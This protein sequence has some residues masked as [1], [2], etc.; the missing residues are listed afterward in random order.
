[1][2]D[3]Q[4]RQAELD[5]EAMR[6]ELELA[7]AY[8]ELTKAM[9]NR[10]SR[11][12]G[13]VAGSSQR[14]DRGQAS[15]I[16]LQP[17]PLT[18]S[19]VP[20]TRDVLLQ[21]ELLTCVAENN[22]T[23]HVHGNTQTFVVHTP[24]TSHAQQHTHDAPPP[25]GTREG[26]SAHRGVNGG[27]ESEQVQPK[28]SPAIPRT[29]APTLQPPRT[30][31]SLPQGVP[32]VTAQVEPA[33]PTPF[34]LATVQGVT[35]HVGPTGGGAPNHSE[36]Q[37]GGIGWD[38]DDD[39]IIREAARL[40]QEFPPHPV[41]A[42]VAPAWVGDYPQQTSRAAAPTTQVGVSAQHRAEGGFGPVAASP[43]P[44][45]SS[46]PM[47]QRHVIAQAERAGPYHP[48][49]RAEGTVTAHV[50]PDPST[51]N[52]HTPMQRTQVQTGG[53]A[54][55]NFF[56]QISGVSEAVMAQVTPAPP[57]P[58]PADP[59][60]LAHAIPRGNAAE[61]V[62]MEISTPS[63]LRSGRAV[64]L[65]LN[66][67]GD[68]H[69]LVVPGAAPLVLGPSHVHHATEVIKRRLAEA[70]EWIEH[71]VQAAAH[72]EVEFASEVH[73]HMH[74]QLRHEASHVQQMLSWN[75][76]AHN[77]ILQAEGFL[78][79]E[80]TQ[81]QARER[82]ALELGAHEAI[83]EAE[84][85]H[86]TR[87]DQIQSHAMSRYEHMQHQLR[88]EHAN[89]VAQ[90]RSEQAALEDLRREANRVVAERQSHFDKLI[91][92]LARQVSAL[93]VR[94]HEREV[95]LRG[96]EQSVQAAEVRHRKVVGMAEERESYHRPR[97]PPRRGGPGLIFCPP[98]T[99]DAS[100]IASGKRNPYRFH[101]SGRGQVGA[102]RGPHAGYSPY[103]AP[104]REEKESHRSG[105]RRWL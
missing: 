53:N 54:V 46:T 95:K 29:W 60:P 69:A 13:S 88:E 93:Q 99:T 90:A 58:L 15:H 65:Q 24:G 34:S 40:E 21:H 102:S 33:G 27:E 4:R 83:V 86:A 43:S 42:Q 80:W 9:S 44:M 91:N 22:E 94:D 82:S 67:A 76:G 51:L 62:P 98:Q 12:G 96:M 17:N 55:E 97:E 47:G 89:A 66:L 2:A 101:A 71:R 50:A 23:L 32:E 37:E 26:L 10:G 6:A 25:A 45:R 59:Q 61:I 28:G 85:L 87:L 11:A 56:G 68:D 81:M 39:F 3:Q 103:C 30:L 78:E 20:L 7:Q 74:D 72:L 77:Q 52:P 64:P 8:V 18:G 36:T 49:R 105:T 38:V 14:G 19:M 16:A 1:M 84:R 73:A 100:R 104:Q 57:P 70:H 35:A 48:G 79:S 75:L 92:D 31:P 5:E 63:P 41:M